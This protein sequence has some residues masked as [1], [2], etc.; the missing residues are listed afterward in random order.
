MTSAIRERIL[1]FLIENEGTLW[2]ELREL[3]AQASIPAGCSPVT[4][5][6]WIHQLT[7]TNGPCEFVAVDD[8]HFTIK[9]RGG[10]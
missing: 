5:G 3:R 4:A 9:K 2:E 6:Q 7:R 10:R 8:D 1:E